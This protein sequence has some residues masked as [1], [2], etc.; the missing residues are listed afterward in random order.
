[1]SF[2]RFRKVIGFGKMFKFF[3]LLGR[4]QEIFIS[5]FVIFRGFV[6]KFRFR[7]QKQFRCRWFGLSTA[8]R[9]CDLELLL[10]FMRTKVKAGVRNR[11][12][13]FFLKL[14]IF[15]GGCDYQVRIMFFMVYSRNV[16]QWFFESGKTRGSVNWQ[17]D[18]FITIFCCRKLSEESRRVQRRFKGFIGVSGVGSL[19]KEQMF[20]EMLLVVFQ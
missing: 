18:I 19:E 2:F 9:S 20:V 14:F 6:F 5:S 17:R 1:M 10:I 7:C 3:L 15:L 13:L 16:W 8:L 11:I 4:N 12:T